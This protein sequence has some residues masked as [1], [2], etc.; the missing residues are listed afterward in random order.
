MCKKLTIAAVAVVL[1][2]LVLG[3]TQI[4][5]KI[6]GY[7]S[8][9]WN[10]ADQALT[11]QVPIDM[12]I[13]RIDAEVKKLDEDIKTA[14]SNLYKNEVA[15][16]R[17][18]KDLATTKAGLDKEE[19]ALAAVYKQLDSGTK[20]V[21]YEGREFPADQVR[22]E[23]ARRFEAFE[24]AGNEYKAKKAQLDHKKELLLTSKQTID[25]MKAQKA[26]LQ[27]KVTDLR[28]QYEAAKDAQAKSAEPTDNSRVANIKN[29]MNKVEDQ[30]KL[31]KKEAE[32]Q[33]SFVNTVADDLKTKDS[34][35]RAKAH[36]GQKTDVADKP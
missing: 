29:D 32:A 36:F 20:V 31:L 26:E 7:V 21:T 34:L 14:R 16:E 22:A 8:L 9:W 19:A 1:G 18:E 13:D 3:G 11:A 25:T 33:G 23:F 24:A 27:A 12:E 10:K 35:D 4:G 17:L 5:P 15:L 6:P 28:V 2:L 30:I